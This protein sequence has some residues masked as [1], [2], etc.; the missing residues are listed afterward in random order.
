[1]MRR[2]VGSRALVEEALAIAAL[3]PTHRVAEVVFGLRAP[4]NVPPLQPGPAE[5]LEFAA[6]AG[7]WAVVPIGRSSTTTRLVL[8]RDGRMVV[9]VVDGDASRFKVEKEL[10]TVVCVPA[11]ELADDDSARRVLERL[12]RS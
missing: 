2:E 11:A 5:R 8:V 4:G 9:A 1:M 12:A 6:R 7:D 10:S 3:S